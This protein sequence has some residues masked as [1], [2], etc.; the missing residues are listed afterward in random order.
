MSK[1]SL[2][3]LDSQVALEKFIVV[4]A[5]A[6]AVAGNAPSV[7]DAVAF[8]HDA[9]GGDARALALVRSLACA[10]A[11]LDSELTKDSNILEEEALATAAANRVILPIQNMRLQALIDVIETDG[12]GSTVCPVQSCES[13]SHSRGRL[14]RSFLGCHGTMIVTVRH[15]ICQNPVCRHHFSPACDHLHLSNGQFTPGCAELVTKLSATLPHGKAV[16]FLGD[17]LQV[18][19]SSHAAQDLSQVRGETLLA[20]DLAAAAVHDPYDN[21][22]FEREYGRPVDAVPAKDAP[23]VAYLEI[24]GVFPMTREKN[25][26]KSHEV[27]G[28]R[29]GKGCKYDMEG[30]E[31]KNAVLYKA[32]DQA[33]EMPSRGCILNR[34]YVS[35]LGNCKVFGLLVWLMILKMRF[36]QA[37]LLVVLSDGA[38]WIRTLADWL[39]MDNR[40]LLILDFFHAVH[41]VGDLARAIYGDNTEMCRRKA[42]MWKEVI[43][44][45]HVAMLIDDFKT[46]HDSRPSVQKIIDELVVYF[47]NNKDRMNYPIY[48][49]AGLRYTS[50]IV[51]SANFNVTGARLKQQGMRWGE[52][53]AREMAH[54]RADLCNDRWSERTR[55]LLAA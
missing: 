35:Y 12:H 38:E 45:G 20:C 30:R 6:G 51:E 37:K 42:K 16:K 36:D 34:R 28:A 18:D 25:A 50:G 8:A 47:E 3:P 1:S 29:G 5:H 14:R 39:P 22:G 48:K 53:G 15:S 52:K 43:E 54:L 44:E 24:D 32:S 2:N 40:V 21:K 33:E 7:A 27:A 19:V 46:M 31:V 49:A 17:L 11:Y 13:K 10:L 26:E 9:L 55:Q 23:K 4:I 41:R